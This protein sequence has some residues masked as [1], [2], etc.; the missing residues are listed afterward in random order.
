MRGNFYDNWD[1]VY[2]IQF[3]ENNFTV[4][5]NSLTSVNRHVNYK[6]ASGQLSLQ[7]SYKIIEN[8]LSIEF[9]PIV[10]IN[11]KFTIANV[12]ANTIISGTTLRA[13]DILD[14]SK[15][16]FYPTVGIIFGV[17][18][19]RA[20]ISYQYGF[21]N[22]LGNLNHLNLGYNYNGNPGIHNSNLIIYL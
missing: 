8:Q 12:D 14:I 6:L 21:N 4:V 19:F 15:F 17:R 1:M 18:H 20:N 16:N 10:Q 2:N 5:T 22:M 3:S 11:G 9:W 13:K 7:A